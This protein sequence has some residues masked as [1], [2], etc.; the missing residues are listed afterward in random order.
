MTA[1]PFAAIDAA[2]HRAS[3]VSLFNYTWTLLDK[4]DRTREESDEMV[5]AAY[6]S[7]WHWG[8]VGEPINFA[9]GEWQVSRCCAEAGMSEAALHHAG[10]YLAACERD[11]YGPFDLA[12]AHE[13]MAR[14]L[15][16]A[17]RG[18][19]CTI[20]I[21]KARQIGAGIEKDEERAWLEENL[22]GI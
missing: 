7:R 11:D 17:G 13:G 3:A 9:R 2:G 20:H 4:N 19:D 15:H 5:R 18:E 14:A 16:A 1:D 6:A 22:A 10:L 8:V 21:E 12:F